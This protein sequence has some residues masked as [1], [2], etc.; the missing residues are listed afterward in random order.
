MRLHLI[1]SDQKSI[2]TAECAFASLLFHASLI[3]LAV[4]V[5]AGAQVLAVD[6]LL[7]VPLVLLPPDRREAPPAGQT[8]SFQ[9]GQ[10]GGLFAD[11]AVLDGAFPWYEA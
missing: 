9:V 5:I 2:Q 1:E 10:A 8:E 3:W 11:G 4:G 7:S 6:A